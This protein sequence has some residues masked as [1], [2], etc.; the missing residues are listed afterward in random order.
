[1]NKKQRKN[2]LNKENGITGADVLIALL[3]I[4]TTIGVI[5]TVYVNLV[6]GS[7]G[8]D[9]KAGATRIATNI[10]ENTETLYYDEIQEHLDTL[11]NLGTA[12]KIDSIYT[13]PGDSGIKVFNTSIPKGYK[14]TIELKNSYGAEEN[15]SY[16]LVKK[17]TVKLEY[18][19]DGQPKQ[20][21]LSKVLEREV[22]REC[23]S[24]Q[25]EEE[26]IRQV[27]PN[28]TEYVMYSQS[29]EGIQPGVKIVC[30]IQY[31]A[32]MKK[33]K[34]VENTNSLWYSYS[35]KQWARILILEADEYANSIDST[36]KTVTNSEI[37]KSDKS[38]VWIPRFGVENAGD[39]EGNTK[40]KYKNTDSAIVNSY[41][42]EN[43]LIYNHL[44]NIEWSNRGIS[45]EN[46]AELGKW[47]SYSDL[48]QRGTDAYYLQNSQYG[49]ML[50]Y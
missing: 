19:V 3:I 10:M 42:E 20:V 36:T 35:S 22:I 21:E 26:Y 4:L 48:V 1:M 28:G 24:P 8:I 12:T 29:A 9:R 32:Q 31:D 13:I 7:K 37:L 45:F 18:L 44:A 27:I 30:P 34:I 11:S 6:L 39:L 41:Y 17:V 25:L 47:A 43:T 46:N 15:S 5:G 16:D 2:K 49:P 38:Y 40:F 23:N 33:Y 50:E 14:A